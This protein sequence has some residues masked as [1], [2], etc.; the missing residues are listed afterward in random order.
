MPPSRRPRSLPS[1]ALVVACLALV[2]ALSG[3]AVAAG[4]VAQARHADKADLAAR[5]L[6]SDRLQGRT[7]SQIAAAGA[8]AGAQLPGPAA[9]A[10][11]LVSLK[12]SN[13]APLGPGQT[14]VFTVSCNLGGRALSAGFSADAPGTV[15]D[16]A[17]WPSGPSAWTL[18]LTNSDAAAA[19][20][21][22]LYVVCLK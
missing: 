15:V 17:S 7:A 10:A 11:D 12:S 20:T 19:H 16:S 13:V 6:D 14:G 2:V 18:R 5:A 8:R 9:S 4:I 1:P 22:T 3:T 21:L